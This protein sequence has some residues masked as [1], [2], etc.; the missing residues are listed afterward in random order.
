MDFVAF[1]YD[2]SWDIA[3]STNGSVFSLP[4]CRAILRR[5]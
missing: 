5:I 4:I 2:V 1:G 3:I